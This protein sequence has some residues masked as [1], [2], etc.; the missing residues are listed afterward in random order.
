MLY[1]PDTDKEYDN[2]YIT[3]ETNDCYKQEFAYDAPQIHLTTLKRK[4]SN[5][6]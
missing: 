1:V 5:I 6:P 3:T 4:H 2:V